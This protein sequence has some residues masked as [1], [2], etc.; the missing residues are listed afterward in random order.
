MRECALN[1]LA[2]FHV[3]FLFFLEWRIKRLQVQKARLFSIIVTFSTASQFVHNSCLLFVQN[4]LLQFN[5]F[6]HM[7]C[8]QRASDRQTSSVSAPA[9]RIP[10]IYAYANSYYMAMA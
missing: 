5:T 8:R 6:C 9:S 10:S 1:Q 3:E 4:Y 7:S 2:H